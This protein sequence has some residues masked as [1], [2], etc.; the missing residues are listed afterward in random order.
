MDKEMVQKMVGKELVIV[1]AEGNKIV[2]Y[3][4]NNKNNKKFT[5][6]LRK[7]E[8]MED[9]GLVLAKSSTAYKLF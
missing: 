9:A 7:G 1:S 8:T 2:F 6:N 3:P 5:Y 4:T